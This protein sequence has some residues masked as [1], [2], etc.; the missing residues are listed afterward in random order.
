MHVQVG[1]YGSSARCITPDVKDS[2]QRIDFGDADVK[3]G[4]ETIL[5][6]ISQTLQS[7][8]ALI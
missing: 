7:S 5:F 1:F 3:T 8:R 6:L 2:K 4:K